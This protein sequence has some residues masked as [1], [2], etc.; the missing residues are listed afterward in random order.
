MTVLQAVGLLLSNGGALDIVEQT[1]LGLPLR[2][3]YSSLPVQ[4]GPF[5][6]IRD[7]YYAGAMLENCFSSG[8]Y[9]RSGMLAGHAVVGLSDPTGGMKDMTIA[10][11]RLRE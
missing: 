8:L 10:S 2:I 11:I 3:E 5:H 1:I 6:Y 4:S 9:K 7:P